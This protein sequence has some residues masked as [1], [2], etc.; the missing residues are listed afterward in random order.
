MRE[1]H[2][3]SPLEVRAPLFQAL[4]ELTKHDILHN[5]TE[6][7]PKSLAMHAFVFPQF[8]WF[9]LLRPACQTGQA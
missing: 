7:P 4:L 8:F 5:I 3:R 6:Y 2:V 1:G 9:D